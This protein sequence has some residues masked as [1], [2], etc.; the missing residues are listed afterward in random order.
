[1]QYKRLNIGQS[2]LMSRLRHHSCSSDSSC[3]GSVELCLWEEICNDSMV[4]R[5]RWIENQRCT[6]D[7]TGKGTPNF[8]IIEKKINDI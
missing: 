8:S 6:S 2:A 7:G 3:N 4:E 5:V 1:M